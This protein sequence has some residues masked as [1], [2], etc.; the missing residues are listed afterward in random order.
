[1]AILQQFYVTVHLNKDNNLQKWYLQNGT[2]KFYIPEIKVLSSIPAVILFTKLSLC[3]PATKVLAIFK[4]KTL[5]MK[6][7]GK[8][9]LLS[10][11]SIN[12]IAP[13][14]HTFFCNKK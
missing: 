10:P 2:P 6:L 1:M 12:S 9:A 4:E 3:M 5:H 7:N 11:H 14:T 8:K 13:I